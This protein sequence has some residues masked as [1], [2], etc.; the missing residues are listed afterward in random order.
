MAPLIFASGTIVRISKIEI[1]GST[2]MNRKNS[3]RNSPIVPKNV[4][5]SQRVGQNMPQDDGRKSRCRLVTTITKRSS[6][7]PTLTTIA[8]ANSGSGLVRTLLIHRNCG[9]TM[10]ERISAQ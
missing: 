6:H 4:I 9:M 3:V 2:R 5:Q 1:I 7:I 8:M 10:L